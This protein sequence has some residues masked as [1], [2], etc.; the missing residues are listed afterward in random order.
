MRNFSRLTIAAALIAATATAAAAQTH[1]RA[2][3]PHAAQRIQV[4]PDSVSDPYGERPRD[5][6]S[7][8]P[9]SE[10]PF[11]QGCDKRGFW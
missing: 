2:Y 6:N 11:A 3:N 9:C 7:T 5:P 1:G 8:V 10:R 4:A